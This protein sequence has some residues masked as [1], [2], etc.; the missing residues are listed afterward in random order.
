LPPPGLTLVAMPLDRESIEP[1]FKRMA[2]ARAEEIAQLGK[3]D[4]AR[5]DALRQDAELEKERIRI[6]HG[7]LRDEKERKA[8]NLALSGASPRDTAR[9]T[10][11]RNDY[12]TGYRRSRAEYVGPICL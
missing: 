11:I 9:Q 4:K 2:D 3:P 5:V 6:T 10:V 7:R 1:E 12:D 8:Q